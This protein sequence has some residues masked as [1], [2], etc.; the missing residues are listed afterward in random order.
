M[1][2]VAQDRAEC[3]S[4]KAYISA[5]YRGQAKNEILKGLA[6][7]SKFKEFLASLEKY[8]AEFERVGRVRNVS[9]K[10]RPPTLI[11]VEEAATSA[12]EMNMGVFWP[13][14]VWE[15]HNVGVKLAKC[16][17]TSYVHNGRKLLG[18]IRDEAQHGCPIGCI[19]L[20]EV[21]SRTARRVTTVADD[22]TNLRKGQNA[23]AFEM[24]RKAVTSTVQA[25]GDRL[26]GGVEPWLQHNDS[27]NQICFLPRRPSGP[28]LQCA[29]ESW[30]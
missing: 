8:E 16:D 15:A 6:D 4:C 14:E 19:K 24:V 29:P 11:Q 27:P 10:F 3:V 2:F 25:L 26:G 18:I 23:E 7:P 13:K 1:G 20:K 30:G 5:A 17:L 21:G 22:A 28:F 12:G 9:E